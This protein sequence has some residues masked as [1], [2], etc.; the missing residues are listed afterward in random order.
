M[1]IMKFVIALTFLSLTPPRGNC[2]L[3]DV[4]RI[5]DVALSE[6]EVD[7][8][9]NQGNSSIQIDGSPGLSCLLTLHRDNRVALDPY[10]VIAGPDDLAGACAQPGYVKVVDSI[11]W[12]GNGGPNIIGCAPTPGNCI[13]VVRYD[14][15]LEWLLWMH[16]YSHS[17][18]LG[19]V[20]TGTALMNPTI[21]A[22]HNS[23]PSSDC[24]LV[25]NTA[26]S[27]SSGPPQASTPVDAIPVSEFVK[28][29][30]IE[31]TPYAQAQRYS[32]RDVDQL[33]KMLNDVRLSAYRGNVAATLGMTGHKRASSALITLVSSGLDLT[34]PEDR[35]VC[36]AALI[37]LGYVSNVKRDRESLS[38]LIHG[39][40]N[41]F[42]EKQLLPNGA[43]STPIT[44]DVVE[45]T[46]SSFIAAA[47]MG[48]A[49]SGTPKAGEVLKSLQERPGSAAFDLFIQRTA[50]QALIEHKRV[51]SDGLLRYYGAKKGN[52][53]R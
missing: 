30:F 15:N 18:G 46:V 38:F 45:T 29:T 16:E 49:L 43:A 7:N 26:S 53:E 21:D 39:T 44:S 23:L 20:T 48:L 25:Q 19:H 14:P 31:G 4:S 35:R 37:S 9:L 51:N 10:G 17:K 40:S 3:I 12:C 42:W 52:Y 11:S 34:K 32:G 1:R 36:I 33:I 28:K 41:S 47:M 6:A 27:G 8:I 22:T 24:A 2:Q 5:S 13:V 50:A